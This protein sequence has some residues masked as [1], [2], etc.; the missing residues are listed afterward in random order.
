MALDLLWR[1]SMLRV[2]FNAN[3]VPLCTT[4]V[5]FRISLIIIIN[6]FLHNDWE[7]SSK[8]VF[9]RS[10]GALSDKIYWWTLSLTFVHQWPPSMSFLRPF[11][12]LQWIIL[13]R[14]H[15]QPLSSWYP[16]FDWRD[17]YQ[18]HSVHVDVLLSCLIRSTPI[19]SGTSMDHHKDIGNTM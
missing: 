11:Q 17:R 3:A 13:R 7:K 16:V 19:W 6:T 4:T 14:L 8:Y 9:V 5:N 18:M 15:C 2:I 10:W 12:C 1:R